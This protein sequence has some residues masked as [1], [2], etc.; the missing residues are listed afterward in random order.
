MQKIFLFLIL[1]ISWKT[2]EIFA[3][4]MDVPVYVMDFYLLGN[5]SRAFSDFKQMFTLQNRIFGNQV[6]ASCPAFGDSG[7][8]K[9][10]VGKGRPVLSA[11]CLCTRS[12]STGAVHPAAALLGDDGDGAHPQTAFPS[13]TLRGVLTEVPSCCSPVPCAR[14]FVSPQPGRRPQDAA[15]AS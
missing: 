3:L 1:C 11:P 14:R 12:P 10:V 15:C 7:R 9:W 2:R 8:G 6:F 4:L 5:T 13:A